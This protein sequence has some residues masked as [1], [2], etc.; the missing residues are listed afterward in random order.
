MPEKKETAAGGGGDG[1]DDGKKKEEGEGVAAAVAA[2]AAKV[3]LPIRSIAEEAA[4]KA[5]QVRLQSLREKVYG[6]SDAGGDKDAKDGK[7][8][9]EKADKTEVKTEP[10]KD[11][12]EEEEEEEA[13][14]EDDNKSPAPRPS[15]AP[16]PLTPNKSADSAMAPGMQSPT[17]GTW[18]DGASSDNVL[19]TLQ[20]PTTTSWRPTDV[21]GPITSYR[22]SLVT[23]PSEDEIA[24]V[25][26]AE[27]IEEEE[28]PESSEGEEGDGEGEAAGKEAGEKK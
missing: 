10:T 25:E 7:G 11:E 22:G 3:T 2:T 13:E 4:A 16:A 18:R 20:S 6:K 17:T 1:A 23:S 12:S 15:L 26:R 21:D 19:R 8:P 9:G 24:A 27:T 5:K 14:S 28:E